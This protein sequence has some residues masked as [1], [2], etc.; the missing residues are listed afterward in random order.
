MTRI[1]RQVLPQD[2]RVTSGAK[3]ILDQ[4]IMQFSAVLTHAARQE[5]RRDGRLTIIADDLFVGLANL[6]LADYVEPMSEYLR[7]YRESVN[8]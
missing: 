4:C 7:L 3:E 6:V 1:V 8:C 2:S 5:C